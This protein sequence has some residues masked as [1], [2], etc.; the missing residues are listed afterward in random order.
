MKIPIEETQDRDGNDIGA[1][2][3]GLTEHI[4][5]LGTHKTFDRCIASRLETSIGGFSGLGNCEMF[6]WGRDHR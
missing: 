5:I 1:A 6:G 3:V 4:E 2:F